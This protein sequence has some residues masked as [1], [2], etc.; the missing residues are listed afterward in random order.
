VQAARPLGT[1]ELAPVSVGSEAHPPASGVPYV[2][3]KALVAPF[4][5]PVRPSS[6]Q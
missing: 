5:Q 4:F 1:L 3:E 6:N 2:P